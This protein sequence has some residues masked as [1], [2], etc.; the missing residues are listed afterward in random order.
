MWTF[1]SRLNPHHPKFAWLSL[2]GVAFADLY[3]RM[4]AKGTITDIT[5]F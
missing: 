4:L 2:F 3:V 1:I 5:F